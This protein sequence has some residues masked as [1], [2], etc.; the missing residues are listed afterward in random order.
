VGL[1]EVASLLCVLETVSVLAMQGRTRM[2][3]VVVVMTR[4]WRDERREHLS[5]RELGSQRCVGTAT[6][7]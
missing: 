3:Q 7:M 4:A 1:V 5:R 6:R 2:K